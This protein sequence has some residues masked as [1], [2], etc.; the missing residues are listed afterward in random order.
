MPRIPPTNVLPRLLRG[1]PG[2]LS[3]EAHTR[4]SRPPHDKG[5][6]N[7]AKDYDKGGYFPVLLG[8]DETQL[9]AIAHPKPP[10]P[11]AAGL[12]ADWENFGE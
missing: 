3:G 9:E 4:L 7:K 5:T 6:T 1:R 10:S 11:V 12:F 2:V 8:V